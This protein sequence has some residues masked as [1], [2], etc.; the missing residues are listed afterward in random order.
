VHGNV[1]N[2]PGGEDAPIKPADYYQLTKYMAEPWVLDYHQKD[3]FK[4][5]ILRPAA[6][7][8]PGDSER[9]FMIFKRVASG[10]FPM[11]DNSKTL[12]HPL[13]IDSLVE[14]PCRWSQ[15]RARA[16]ARPISSPTSSTWK[17][18]PWCAR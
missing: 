9:S 14:T 2:P 11:F 12:Y 5:S 4:T 7:Y 13:Y 3:L 15:R 17:S 6:I 1:D 16:T 18:R 10:T 8:G